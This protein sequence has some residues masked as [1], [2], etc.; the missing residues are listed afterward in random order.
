M[1]LPSVHVHLYNT[2][3]HKG[4]AACVTLGQPAQNAECDASTAQQYVL[5]RVHT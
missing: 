5:Y 1:D 3:L 2:S 4:N